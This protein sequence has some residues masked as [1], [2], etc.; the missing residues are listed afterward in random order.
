M[1]SLSR[2]AP[3][4]MIS[5]TDRYRIIPGQSFSLADRPTKDN[6]NWERSDAETALTAL[7]ARM[8]ALQE[9]MYAEGKHAVLFVFQAMD[10]GGKDST[11]RA[12]F[13]PL[14]PQGVKVASFKAPSSEELRHDYLWRIHRETP[15]KGVIRIFNRSHYEDVLIARVKNLCPQATW[16]KRYDHINAFEQMLSDEGTT[17]VKFFLHISKGYQKKRL[18]RRL[19]RPDKQWKFNPDDLKERARWDEYQQAFEAALSRCSTPI[20]PWYVI[21]GETRWYRNLLVA[22]I[23]TKTLESLKIKAPKINFDPSSIVIE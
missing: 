11:T 13:G 2:S 4:I 7:H 9:M 6:G 21:P 18:Q 10:A 22:S 17:I 19:D 1:T 23:V 14:N 12:V 5:D 8:D 15:G 3:S 16:E 20:A